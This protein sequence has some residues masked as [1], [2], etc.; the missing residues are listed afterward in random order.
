MK[1]LLLALLS[2]AFLMSCAT[3]SPPTDAETSTPPQAAAAP[4]GTPDSEIGLAAGTAFEQPQQQAIGFN[5]VDPGESELRAR[6]NS[7]FP[8]AVPHSTEDLETITFE[9]NPCLE[10]HDPSV[11]ADMGAVAVPS[12]HNVDLRRKPTAEGKDVVGARWV[13]TSCHVAQTDAEPL[14]AISSG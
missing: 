2:I 5:T 6:P 1:K 4:V 3:Q 8:P 10:C 12:S 7:E 11:A 13:C 14:V 9:E